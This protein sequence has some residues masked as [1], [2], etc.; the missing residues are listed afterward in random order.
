MRELMNNR[1]YKSSNDLNKSFPKLSFFIFTL[2]LPILA[3]DRADALK[4]LLAEESLINSQAPVKQSNKKRNIK[5]TVSLYF[6]NEELIDVINLIA[7][8]KGV[9]IILPTGA[10]GLTSKITMHLEQK[11]DAEQAW[12]MLYTIL[13]VAGYSLVPSGNFYSIVKTTKDVVREPLPLYVGIAPEELPDT[14]QRIRYLYYLSNIKLDD[15]GNSDIL[16]LLQALLPETSNYKADAQTNGLIITDKSNNIRSAMKIIV[17]LDQAEEQERPE[18][19]RLRYTT[20]DTVAQLFT[21]QILKTTPEQRLRYETR[22]A[23]EAS[24]FSRAVKVISEPRT[25]SLIILGRPQATE[26]VREFID[27]YIDIAPD[28]GKS[29]LHVYEL[30][31]LDAYDF[32][33]VLQK[34]IESSRTG[35]TEQSKAGGPVSGTERYF[36]EIKIMADR[37]KT[38]SGTEAGGPTL[39]SNKIIVAARNDDWEY[40]KKLIEEL[41][42]PQ[43]L[44]IIEVLVADLT[45]ADIR[46]LGTQLRNAFNVSMPKNVNV[47]GAMLPGDVI[48][49]DSTGD[50]TTLQADLLRR[51]FNSSTGALDPNCD[52][53]PTPGTCVSYATLAPAGATLVSFNDPDGKTWGLLQIRKILTNHKVLSHPHVIA[54]NNQQATI[55]FKEERLVPDEAS[56]ST[57]GTT[58]ATRKW[59]P[60]TFD[61]KITPRVSAADTVNLT[62]SINIEQ[63]SSATN[64]A[65]ANKISRNVTTN[66]NV[67]NKAILAL[68][69]LNRLDTANAQAS[70][71]LLSKIPIIGW[72]FK[73]RE[74]TLNQNNLTVFICPTIVQPRLRGGA[75]TYTREYI[76]LSVDYAREGMLFDGLRD[77]ITRWFFKSKSDDLVDDA[78]IKFKKRDK[79]LSE[80]TTMTKE[81]LVDLTKPTGSREVIRPPMPNNVPMPTVSAI[82]TDVPVDI[83]DVPVKG[84]V[85]VIPEDVPVKGR[86]AVIPEAIEDPRSKRLKEMLA[87]ENINL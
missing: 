64:F 74:T 71:P 59:I 16:V 61:V 13:D 4:N 52:T 20:S 49:T 5:K 53:S 70:W 27:R 36:D 75:S 33:D 41:D 23:A 29:I 87:Q 65:N 69:G 14:D 34:I 54:I 15:T 8:L 3:D 28:Q 83:I 57:G 85:A 46:S 79:F 42:T 6:D 26:R 35:G 77:P 47:Q 43:S 2:M 84:K 24:F 22:K 44:T 73:D 10:N 31:Y 50:P 78:F 48:L 68:G 63:F 58:T 38:A 1:N 37:P 55:T 86:V 17:A 11:L 56:G 39:G 80:E 72:L 30:Q 51:A 82:P 7:G 25:N 81:I 19:L 67:P 62:V 21:D 45:L 32:V 76:D 12:D 18:I 66:A 60:A 9:N 40:I